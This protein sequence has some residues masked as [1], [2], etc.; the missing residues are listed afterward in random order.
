MA[1]EE[2]CPGQA[3]PQ[4]VCP[5]CGSPQREDCCSP[6]LRGEG[7]IVSIA[8]WINEN[9]RTSPNGLCIWLLRIVSQ[10]M[11]SC[12]PSSKAYVQATHEGDRLVNH[13]E[14]LVLLVTSA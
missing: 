12:I 8:Q 3:Y 11:L 6:S 7:D 2:S 10:D 9:V 5:T 1:Y 13:T 4:A 14:L